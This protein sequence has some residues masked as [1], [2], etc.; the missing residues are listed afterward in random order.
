[1]G[2]ARDEE[3][4]SLYNDEKTNVIVIMNESFSDL[5]TTYNLDIETIA[6]ISVILDWDIIFFSQN[7]PKFVKRIKDAQKK[8]ICKNYRY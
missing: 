3:K 2:K 7:D 8:T 4:K 5:K 1:M 6:K